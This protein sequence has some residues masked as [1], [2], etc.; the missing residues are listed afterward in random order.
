[1]RR[2]RKLSLLA[3]ALT[4][5]AIAGTGAPPAIDAVRQV[6]ARAAVLMGGGWN[7]EQATRDAALS[8]LKDSQ[9][10][11]MDGSQLERKQK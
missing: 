4:R 1:M 9:P 3:F 7:S 2:T 11:P 6:R 5:P 10:E 8:L